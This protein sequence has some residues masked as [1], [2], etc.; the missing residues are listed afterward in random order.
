MYLVVVHIILIA[1]LIKPEMVHT[2]TYKLGI[3]PSPLHYERLLSRHL[4][5]NERIQEGDIIFLGDS[6]MEKANINHITSNG[7]NLGISMDWTGGLSDRIPLYRTLDRASLLMIHIGVN[8]LSLKKG[9]VPV[10]FSNYRNMLALL[11]HSMPVVLNSVLPLATAKNNANADNQKIE[12]FNQLIKNYADS[13][14]NYYY[15]DIAS[16]MKDETGGLKATYHIGD[17]I[18]LNNQ[19]Y[20]VFTQIIKDFLMQQQWI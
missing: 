20:Q 19:G 10:C 9:Q 11:P 13:H 3:F 17:F 14:P 2:A 7:H 12:Q 4:L 6:I 18:H 5:K 16:H 8:D 15:L 1:V